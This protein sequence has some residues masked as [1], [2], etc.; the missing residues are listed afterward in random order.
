MQLTARVL[1]VLCLVI[2]AGLGY[3]ALALADDPP[4]T[5]SDR[6]PSAAS[7]QRGPTTETTRV[8]TETSADA[9]AARAST[10][11]TDSPVANDDGMHVS[12]RIL[13][14]GRPISCA[15]VAIRSGLSAERSSV[16]T[17]SDSSGRFR[18]RVPRGTYRVECDEGTIPRGFY[19]S[20]TVHHDVQVG[21]LQVPRAIDFRGQ[22]VDADHTP[23]A[24][25]RI[26]LKF[27]P[28][29]RK[30]APDRGPSAEPHAVSN[31]TGHFVVPRL[32]AHVYSMLI[33]APDHPDRYATVRLTD[34][35]QRIHTFTLPRGKR[36]RGQVVDTEG[37]PVS[38]ALIVPTEE[39]RHKPYKAARTDAGGSYA[40]T[41]LDDDDEMLTVTHPDYEP[42]IVA[43]NAT[44]ITLD[45][46]ITLRARV[47]GTTSSPYHLVITKH[48]DDTR[49]YVD[50]PF[51]TEA[52]LHERLAPHT[53]GTFL[54]SGLTKG[55]YGVRVIAASG[56]R[57]KQQRV[58]LRGSTSIELRLRPQPTI[59]VRVVDEAGL[60]LERATVM[61]DVGCVNPDLMER[62]AWFN[63][64][65]TDTAGIARFPT[66]TGEG[67]LFARKAGYVNARTPVRGES[68][69][70]RFQLR[71]RRGGAIEGRL[72][73]T[74][75]LARYRCEVHVWH[76][77][78]DG[79][80]PT[81]HPHASCLPDATGRFRL[82]GL[83]AGRYGIGLHWGHDY[84]HDD[85]RT[86]RPSPATL[87]GAGL[88]PRTV[89]CVTVRDDRTTT[90]NLQVGTWGTINGRVF[91]AGQPIA[92]VMIVGE[93]RAE[94]NLP[95]QWRVRDPD[96]RFRSCTRSEADGSFTLNYLLAGTFHLL[97][98]PSGA[99][100]LGDPVVIHASE[101]GGR[102]DCALQ[103]DAAMIVGRVDTRGWSANRRANSHAALMRTEAADV[104]GYL[105]G[106]STLKPEWVTCRLSSEGRFSFDYV[107]AG[108][109]VVRI[110]SGFNSVFAQRFVH[111]RPN[112][113]CDLGLIDA[114][115]SRAVD[116]PIALPANR[117]PNGFGAWIERV[118]GSCRMFERAV[119][120]PGRLTTTLAPGTY[121]VRLFTRVDWPKDA[122]TGT[123]VGPARRLQVA[124]D[125][126]V[127]P[128]S[129][130]P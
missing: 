111:V 36:T 93:S 15:I 91:C 6:R 62:L 83:P 26:Y 42:K 79:T 47:T 19:R 106:H 126:T 124:N 40:L 70:E 86:R 54:V 80:L 4:S 121:D 64:V 8:G 34:G 18:L 77:T 76:W 50:V 55:I 56:H 60:P 3:L 107:P 85:P 65:P 120:V 89:H 13:Q 1:L 38:G 12:G 69:P 20:I 128:L 114:P 48:A 5:P 25:A 7:R 63:T 68:V 58:E 17:R 46:A 73:S 92:D 78:P 29:D 82:D 87:I 94:T 109:W 113:R 66:P 52:V 49:Y 33:D 21:D 90:C 10:T 95:G 35:A 22:V 32:F 23:V 88:D 97:A 125:G 129:L 127:T 57:S 41:C 105:A 59:E 61:L 108:E 102:Y 96:F 115:A 30:D 44:T 28:D 9:E 37:K 75:A 53:D 51:P 122:L 27:D 84:N 116:I 104:R 123:P 118:E 130:R 72:D 39:M 81:E 119:P 112:Q 101:P 71:L 100:V 16:R 98:V 24:G 31:G 2:A 74:D 103:V 67:W 45:P 11:S 14:D 99:E 117:A 110:S 43:W